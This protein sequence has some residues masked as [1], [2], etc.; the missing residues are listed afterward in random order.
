[1][2]LRCD[3]SFAVNVRTILEMFLFHYYLFTAAFCA[4]TFL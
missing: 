3:V 2:Q 1:M 4:E